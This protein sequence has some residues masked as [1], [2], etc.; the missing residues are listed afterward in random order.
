MI[1]SKFPENCTKSKEFGCR[2]GG[3]GASHV[4]PLNPPM[5]NALYITLTSAFVRRML[6]MFLH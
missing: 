2:G 1:L 6:S 4:P 5:D 3:G